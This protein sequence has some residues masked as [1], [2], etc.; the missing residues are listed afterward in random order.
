[1]DNYKFT[2][3]QNWLAFFFVCI[4]FGAGTAMADRT[5]RVSGCIQFDH[6]NTGY[7]GA[8]GV[9]VEIMDSDADFDDKLKEARTGKDGCFDTTIN[10]KECLLCEADPDLYVKYVTKNG[11]VTVQSDWFEVDFSYRNPDKEDNYKGTHYKSELYTATGDV[12]PLNIHTSITRAWRW[13]SN[14]PGYNTPHVDVQFTGTSDFYN[15]FWDEIF[16]TGELEIKGIKYPGGGAHEY[17]HIHEYGHH[18]MHQFAYFD[19]NL[20]ITG[21]ELSYNND[22]CDGGPAPGTGHCAWC[23]EK[24]RIAFL[25]GWPHWMSDIIVRSLSKEYGIQFDHKSFEDIGL[26]SI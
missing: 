18:W 7:M 2:K 4:F 16:I 3:Q 12:R 23:E 9:T 11:A 1:M 15:A 22:Y 17:T 26:F 19:K 8:D 24:P 5:I 21:T 10:W 6:D 20:G 14:N 13:L 25:E